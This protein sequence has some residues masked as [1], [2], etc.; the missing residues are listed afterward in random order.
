MAPSFSE[1]AKT[2]CIIGYGVSGM[3]ICTDLLKSKANVKI[4]VVTPTEYCETPYSMAVYTSDV[5]LEGGHNPHFD[6]MLK[7]VE[8]SDTSAISCALFSCLS[9]LVALRRDC[10]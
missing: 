6:G 10:C 1:V 2:V 4:V 9:L 7:G 3:S 5:S 8:V